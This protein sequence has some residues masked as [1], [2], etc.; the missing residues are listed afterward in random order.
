MSNNILIIGGTGKTGRRVVERLA[1][2]GHNNVRI[3]S[4][5]AT[6]AFDWQRPETWNE[7][8]RGID[9]VYITFQPDLAVPGTP[10]IIS[11]FTST[12]SANGVRKMI[13]LSG[14]G[15]KEAE[16]CERIVMKNAQA[17]TMIRASWFHQNFNENVFLDPILAG[18]VALPRAE[19]KE[20]FID[21]DDI[22][23]VVVACLTGDNHEGKI[24]ELTGPRLIT[25]PEAIAEIAKVTGREIQFQPLTLEENV[26]LLRQYQVP[27]D[28]IWL[29][30]YLFAETLDGRNSHITTDVENVLGRKPKDFS[31]FV[32]EA[33]GSGVWNPK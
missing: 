21:A 27:E 26:Q 7:A 24:Y 23:D 5:S 8:T 6:P 30:N 13:L 3:G 10:E 28:H 9:S 12:A 2:R 31:A 16:V 29:F 15:E 32:R 22:A 17:W 33:A 20:P 14:R 11:A 1:N 19:T 25:F 18:H 4:R